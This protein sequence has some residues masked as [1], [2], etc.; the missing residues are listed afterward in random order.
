MTEAQFANG[1]AISRSRTADSTG[2]LRAILPLLPAVVFL[3]LIYGYPLLDLAGRSIGIPS[4]T[5]AYYSTFFTTASHVTVFARTFGI[6]LLGA[7]TCLIFGYPLAYT[8]AG[9]TPKW[10]TLLLIGVVA[11]WITSSL[12][13]TFAWVLLLSRNGPLNEALLSLNVIDAPVEVLGTSTAVYIGLVHVHLPLAVLPMYSVMRRIDRRLTLVAEGSGASP[14]RAFRYVYFPLS[15]PGVAAAGVLLFISMLGFY[16]TPLLLGGVGDLFV[17]NLID[18]QVRS[19]INW[20]Y[21][22]AL[23]FIL[24][25][26]TVALYAVYNRFLG[27]DTLTGL[28][29]D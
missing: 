9:L 18:L 4:A 1:H 15:L 12:V 21:G 3:L 10:R 5:G 17:A 28:G 27:L 22:A 11:P 23:G 2:R 26:C 29:N 20:E 6:A 19:L 24:F 13:R 16:I 14:M 8:L 7:V 25:G